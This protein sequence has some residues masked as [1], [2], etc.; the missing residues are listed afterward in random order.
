MALTWADKRRFYV[1]GGAVLIGIALLTV[2]AIS[3]LYEAPSCM[4][5]KL[6]QDEAGIDCGG[7]CAY[8]CAHEVQ[9]PRITFARTIENGNGRTDVIAYIENRNQTAEAKGARYTVEVFDES[10]TLLGKREGMLDLPA[11]STVSLFVPGIYQGIGAAPRAFISFAED[12][13][14]RNARGGEN[15][16]AVSQADLVLGE[17]PRVNV[18]LSNSAP[19]AL[20]NKT[21]IAT[22]FDQTG[23]AIAASQTVVRE[24]AGLGTATAVFTWNQPFQGT[25]ARVEVTSVP[26]LP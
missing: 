6:N 24:I 19:T 14:W 18:I 10:G 21:I 2:F 22:V 23:V 12:T 16:I 13:D 5:Q 7:S 4:D 25:P 17:K 11:R 3:I 8:L 15:A 9:E 20:Y 1:I 26:T